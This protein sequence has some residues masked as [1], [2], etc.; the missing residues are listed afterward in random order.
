[1][2]LAV[3][4][5]IHEAGLMPATLA[6]SDI[7]FLTQCVCLLAA[8]EKPSQLQQLP[9]PQTPK[10]LLQWR[11]SVLTFSESSQVFGVMFDSHV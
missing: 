1:M 10:R 6:P 8:R 7:L 9:P 11:P 4:W 5:E 3:S 2:P